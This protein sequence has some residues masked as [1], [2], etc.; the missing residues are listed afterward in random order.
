MDPCWPTHPLKCGKFH[1]FFFFGPFPKTLL[2]DRYYSK[3]LKELKQSNEESYFKSIKNLCC[4]PGYILLL[5][6]YGINVGVFYAISTLLNTTIVM[7]FDY[8][9]LHEGILRVFTKTATKRK[10]CPCWLQTYCWIY[11]WWQFWEIQYFGSRILTWSAFNRCW[12]FCRLVAPPCSY[13]GETITFI[14]NKK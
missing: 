2:K 5:T 14:L 3:V 12:M 10:F 4:N 9:V 6:T 13:L 8:E 11:A 7:H 1:T